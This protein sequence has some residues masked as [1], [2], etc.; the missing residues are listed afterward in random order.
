MYEIMCNFKWNLRVYMRGP[1]IQLAPYMDKS[2][3][4]DAPD[5]SLEFGAS[6]SFLS[7]FRASASCLPEFRGS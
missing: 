4:R 5:A 6:A 1:P 2:L 7:K 3:N